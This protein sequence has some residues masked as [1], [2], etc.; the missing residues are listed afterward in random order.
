MPLPDPSVIMTGGT[1]DA[2]TTGG[3]PSILT[4]NVLNPIDLT[5][6][7]QAVRDCLKDW[8]F[9]MGVLKG[10]LGP[11]L[12]NLPKQTIDCIAAI[13]AIAQKPI[14]QITD[15]ELGFILGSKVRMLSPV[16]RGL[17][18]Q[19]VPNAGTLFDYVPFFL[20]GI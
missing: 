20:R 12:D 5:T 19:Y 10:A 18:E 14:D 1:G 4:G 17:I 11:N 6:V 13:S 7:K 2:T 15:E 8:A 16:I 9:Y 3:A